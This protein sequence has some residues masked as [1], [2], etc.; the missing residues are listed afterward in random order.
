M[1]RRY[2]HTWNN[3]AVSSAFCITGRRLSGL[4]RPSGMRRTPR[5]ASRRENN[6]KSQGT[7]T[8]SLAFV[9]CLQRMRK[10]VSTAGSAV[11]KCRRMVE[12]LLPALTPRVIISDFI[13]LVKRNGGGKYRGV[14][15]HGWGKTPVA[16]QSSRPQARINFNPFSPETAFSAKILYAERVCPPPQGALAERNPSTVQTPPASEL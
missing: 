11:T 14:T 10:S 2:W 5:G 4:P 13:E 3:A 16:S 7:A 6:C 9:L 8:P 15:V 1:R 12:H